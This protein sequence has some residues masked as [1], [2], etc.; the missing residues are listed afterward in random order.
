MG[1]WLRSG[2]FNVVMP[3]LRNIQETDAA[4]RQTFHRMMRQKTRS[5]LR[6]RGRAQITI[7]TGRQA[8]GGACSSRA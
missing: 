3:N 6:P 7:C 1:K 5:M 8:G 2:N 4:L